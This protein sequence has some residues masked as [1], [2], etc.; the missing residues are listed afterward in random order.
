M[1]ARLHADDCSLKVLTMNLI[2]V[3]QRRSTHAVAQG[4]V[5]SLGG[6]GALLGGL[7]PTLRAGLMRQRRRMLAAAAWAGGRRPLRRALLYRD[8]ALQ[9]AVLSICEMPQAHQRR[10]GAPPTYRVE[11][12]KGCG[13]SCLCSCRRV[14]GRCAL[15]SES[16]VLLHH[17]GYLWVSMDG[18]PPRSASPL[19]APAA[20]LICSK[21]SDKRR[22]I[23]R[24][25]ADACRFS[26]CMW[27]HAYL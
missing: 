10:S 17:W 24:A 11:T 25:V 23:A 6:R 3:A 7:A 16:L 14:Y 9:C 19:W 18:S 1:E 8:A 20:P 12:R 22:D 4:G 5:C 2:L 21:H 26:Q 15:Q 27:Y 13:S